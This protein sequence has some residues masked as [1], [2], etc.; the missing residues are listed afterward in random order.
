MLTLSA[1][2][3][4]APWYP[5][6]MSFE[7][8]DSARTKL[9]EEFSFP[10]SFSGGND[11]TIRISPDDFLTPYNVVYL[12]EDNMFVYGG[13]YG[14]KGGTGA[15][16]AKVDPETLTAVW[17]Q[18]VINTVEANE[19]DYPGV[20][21]I[22][23]DGYLYLIY[24]YRLVKLDPADGSIVAGPLELPTPAAPA[25]TS[26]NGLDAL[27]DG[28]L[29]AK[30]VYRQA[31]CDEQGFS[32]FLN[33]PDPTDVPNSIIVAVDP[34]ALDV[35]DQIETEE[36]IGGRLTSVQ[37]DGQDVIYVAGSTKVFRYVYANQ[38]LALDSS[39]GPVVYLDPSTG[40]T[41]ASAVVVMNDWVVFENNAQ[42]VTSTSAPSPWL[43]VTAINQADDSQVLTTQP[44]K[45]FSSPPQFPIS[46]SPSAVSVDPFHNRI[47]VLDS[48]PGRIAA[49]ELRADGIETLWTERQRTGEFMT[50]VGP[51]EQRVVV[52]TETPPGEF[53]GKN[54]QDRVIWRNAATGEEL[55]HTD[56]MP[57]VSTGTMVEPGYGGRMYYMAQEGKIIELTVQ[58]SS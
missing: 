43:T 37:F 34:K 9:F 49:L 50:L 53:P 47:Y 40:Q 13:G 8:H 12:D 38:Q 52:G 55:A 3:S 19:W 29:I 20:L 2:D 21:S 15:F 33:C 7:H 57:A 11:A 23:D 35:I 44:F 51:P 39:W 18:Q 41:L 4:N 1:Q 58:P 45:E 56:Y 22:L 16:V 28:T 10:G 27:P 25:D 24:G 14:D 36:F 32:A 5:S 26:Y 54:T 46:F 17:T 48:G 30:T 6:L 42:P 31:G